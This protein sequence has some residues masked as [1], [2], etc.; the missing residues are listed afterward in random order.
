MA[1]AMPF[2]F[3]SQQAMSDAAAA[4]S[5][6][7]PDGLPATS[8]SKTGS[9]PGPTRSN[10]ISATSECDGAINPTGMCGQWCKTE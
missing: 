7:S 1:A 10:G 6:G 5:A 3:M 8:V 9:T 4:V 2:V